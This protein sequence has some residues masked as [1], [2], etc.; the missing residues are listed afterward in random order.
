MIWLI[1]SL[2]LIAAVFSWTY[3]F[4]LLSFYHYL[5]ARLEHRRKDYQLLSSLRENLVHERKKKIAGLEMILSSWERGEEIQPRY[6]YFSD[7]LEQLKGLVRDERENLMAVTQDIWLWGKLWTMLLKIERVSRDRRER[8]DVTALRGILVRF[9]DLT[10][11]IVQSATERFSFS[12][13]DA[14]REAV[15]TVRVEKTQAS[16]ISMEE[17]LH[18]AGED[19]RFSYDNFKQWQRL[20][21]N[22]IRNAF[23]AVEAKKAGAGGLGLV[24]GLH[25]AG[26]AAGDGV[27][28]DFPP[29]AGPAL[30]DSLRGREEIGWVKI[31]T[32]P[33]EAISGQAGMPDPPGISVIIED[34]GIGM[35]EA[36]RSS[37]FKKGFTAGKDGGLGLGVTEESIQLIE[38]YGGWEIESQKAVGTRITVG[39]DRQKA[40]KAELILPPEKPFHRRKLIV[41]FSSVLLFLIIGATFL[42]AFYPYSRFWV[43][44]NPAI[45]KLLDEN[46]IAVEAKGGRLLWN[47]R[48]PQ[49][50]T[51]ESHAIGNINRDGKN[52]VLI[53]TKGG[54]KETGHICCLS[55][56]G[57]ELWRFA[58]GSHG[59]FGNTS[60]VYNAD[61][62]LIRD[63]N[64]D[65]EVEII[66]R[67]MNFPWFPCQIATV[68]KRGEMQ[69]SYWHSGAV[70]V[71]LCDDIENDGLPELVFGGVNNS[72][73][74]RAVLGILD[75]KTMRGQSPPYG[76][77]VLPKAQERTYI[78]FPFIKGLGGEN[79]K[80]SQV[81]RF[82]F[83]GRENG[84]DVYKVLVVDHQEVERVFWLDA[85]LASV[86]RIVVSPK[87]R[88]LWQQLRE[89]GILDYDITPEVLESWKK[90]EVWK[91]G[92]KVK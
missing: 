6:E 27:A 76:D 46:T 1:G 74:Y 84:Q 7:L 26:P 29:K 47:W 69:S 75:Y 55:F 40:R 48:I 37:F 11:Q 68:D 23:E 56:D 77:H 15:K 79:N 4:Y 25:E 36:T 49:N 28:A 24:A 43:D 34:S 18:D 70:R 51:I 72:L 10:D 17:E 5:S 62:I 89:E 42:F 3:R 92:V 61:Q 78:K 87:S 52:E 14:V 41:G 59:V 39:I 83:A 65:G 90:I 32:K 88:H 13:N 20:L 60:D 81:G 12:L 38:Q 63:L 82:E 57:K 85:T 66:V 9:N 8:S 67:A 19:V 33:S 54:F 22:L 73:D 71:L 35:D 64:L 91:D 58:L 31:T 86:L 2:I 44:W 21:I 50:L 30:R 16:G 45:V 53:S 80:F